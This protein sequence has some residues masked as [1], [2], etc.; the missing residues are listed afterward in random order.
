VTWASVDVKTGR[1]IE[2]PG[3]R[4]ETEPF[5]IA[6]GAPGG[7]T[8]HPNAYSPDTGYIYIPTWENYSA[9]APQQRPASGP[10]PLIAFGGRIDRTTLKPHAKQADMAG[11]RPGDPSARKMVGKRRRARATSGV[12]AGGNLVFMGNTAAT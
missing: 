8:W 3:A 1:P 2:V 10:P 5:N 11:C 6:P 7:H 12:L 9:M 4:Y